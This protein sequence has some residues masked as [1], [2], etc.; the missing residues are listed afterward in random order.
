MHSGAECALRVSERF[1]VFE[2]VQSGVEAVARAPVR[3]DQR[4]D[5]TLIVLLQRIKLL[6]ATTPHQTT[7]HHTKPYHRSQHIT[8]YRMI[9]SQHTK[10]QESEPSTGISEGRSE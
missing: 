8:S 6:I 5:H 9:T 7:P 1:G 10:T 3:T 2:V 4:F